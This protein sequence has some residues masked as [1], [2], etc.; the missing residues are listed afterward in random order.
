MAISFNKRENEKK[1]QQKRAEK[2]KRKDERK[3]SGKS[4]FDDMIAYVDE[5]GMISDTPPDMQNVEA[6]NQEEILISTP[7]K[8]AGEEE[9]AA[10]HQGHVEY[11]SK[12]KGY[13][14]IKD[15]NTVDKYFFHISHA[16]GA[17]SEGS[18]V[19]F[20]LERGNKGLNAINVTQIERD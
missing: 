9:V 2:Q 17:I 20:D 13:G 18:L 11:F 8:E 12:S 15:R 4:S 7:K 6:I 3:T 16:S 5:N 10:V 19:S 1:K 14:F